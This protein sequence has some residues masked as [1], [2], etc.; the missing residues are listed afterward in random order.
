MTRPLCV[1]HGWQAKKRNER[2]PSCAEAK[3]MDSSVLPAERAY[4]MT[5]A[6]IEGGV[7]TPEQVAEL[8]QKLQRYGGGGV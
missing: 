1:L 5:L 6:F 8:Q 4:T 2:C 7:Y 3:P